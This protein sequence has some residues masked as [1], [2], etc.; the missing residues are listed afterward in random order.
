[1]RAALLLAA[2]LSC[3]PAR[4]DLFTAQLAYHNGDY[5]HAFKDYRDL[6]EL[7]Q[8][9]AQYN[10][11]VMYAKGEGVRQSGGRL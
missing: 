1:M 3:P 9:L 10:V 5:E 4:A 2:V 11:A 6:A 7:G 8:P